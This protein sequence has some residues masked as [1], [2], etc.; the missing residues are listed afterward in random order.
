MNDILAQICADKRDW[1]AAQKARASLA[2]L[3]A[4]AEEQPKARG[5]YAALKHNAMINQ[6]A[7]IAEVKKASPS[8]GLIRT[9]FNPAQLATAYQHA[10]ASCISVLT[11]RTYFQGDDDHFRQA[12]AAIE[13]PMIRKDFMVELYQIDETRALGADCVLLIMAALDNA[14]AQAMLDRAYQWGMDALLEVHDEAELDRA[15]ALNTGDQPRLIGI[16]NRNLKTL[17]VDINTSLAL[18]HRL[19]NQLWVA[20]SG[21]SKAIEM[22]QLHQAGAGAFLIGESLMRQDDVT[23]ALTQLLSEARL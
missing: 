18:A 19:R 16:N 23:S 17:K 10:G 2:D 4:L 6:L 8:K 13:L 1:V 9:D 21:I 7:I 12:R 15:L 22:R 11:D 3:R 14:T 20:E 5:F